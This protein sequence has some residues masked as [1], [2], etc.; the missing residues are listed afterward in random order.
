[1][2]NLDKDSTKIFCALM[3]RMN[4][5]PYHKIFNSPY[6]PLTIENMGGNFPMVWGNGHFYSLCHYYEQN[7]DLMQDPEICFL[8]VDNRKSDE[9]YEKIHIVP[10]SFQNATL[11][12][13]EESISFMSNTVALYLPRMQTSHISFAKFWLDNIAVQGFLTREQ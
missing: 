7:G 2:K 13:Y 8:V 11:G 9:D 1:M 5:R 3:A 10:C 12:I 6:M 4:G